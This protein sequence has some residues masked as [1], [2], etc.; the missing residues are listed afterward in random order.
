MLKHQL[1]LLWTIAVLATIAMLAGCGS[2]SNRAPNRLHADS[3]NGVGHRSR[4]HV[5]GGVRWWIPAHA[6][7]GVRQRTVGEGVDAAVVLWSKDR[8]SPTSRTVIVFLHGYQPNPPSAEGYGDWI[9]HLTSEGDTVIYP[10]YQTVNTK[11]EHYLENALAGIRAGLSAVSVD[12]KGIVLIGHTTGG[13]LAFDCAA[14]AQR[15]GLPAPRAVVAVYPG[16]HPVSGFAVTSSDLSDIPASTRLIAIAGP[17]DPIPN[18]DQEA[19]AL[20]DGATHVPMAQRVYM[21]A[22]YIRSPGPFPTSLKPRRSFWGPVDSLI[23]Q[24]RSVAK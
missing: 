12:P 5:T 18:G 13:A 16:R 22:P 2:A 15:E 7:V 24:A 21:S 17:G 19:H 9:A 8:R 6:I 20:L 1:T 23:S 11:P 14:V 4:L 10:V 3:A